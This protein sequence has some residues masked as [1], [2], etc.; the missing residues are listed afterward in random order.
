MLMHWMGLHVR[1]DK[2]CKTPRDELMDKANLGVGCWGDICLVHPGSYFVRNNSVL[3]GDGGVVY[4]YSWSGMERLVPHGE[5][6]M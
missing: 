1:W 3:H 2:N 6:K 5:L 4:T